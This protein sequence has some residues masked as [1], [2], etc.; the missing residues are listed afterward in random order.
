[1]DYSLLTPEQRQKLIDKNHARQRRKCRVNKVISNSAAIVFLTIIL[2]PII[3]FL[4]ACGLVFWGVKH[5]DNIG[6][7]FE[8]DEMIDDSALDTEDNA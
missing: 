8:E 5:K 6:S 4:A 3:P 1:M 2:T 7:I